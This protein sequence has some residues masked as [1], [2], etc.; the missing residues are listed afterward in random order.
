VSEQIAESDIAIRLV[1]DEESRRSGD[2]RSPGLRPGLE[3]TV[4][5]HL[6]P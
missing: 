5:S 3:P 4:G 6:D 2:D 1:G